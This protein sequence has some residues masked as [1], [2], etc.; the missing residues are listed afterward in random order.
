MNPFVVAAVAFACSI[1]GGLIGVW[2]RPR[3]PESHLDED[4]K[5]LVKIGTGLIGTMSALILGLLVASAT[6]AFSAEDDR[7]QQLATDFV[8]L[9]RGLAHYGPEAA[10]ARVKLRVA[11]EAMRGRVWGA[12][13][14]PPPGFDAPEIAKA[15]GSM[16]DAI[17]D[18]TPHSEGQR[19][20]QARSIEIGATLARTRLALAQGADSSIP[21]PFLVVLMSWLVI[22]F[23]G[24][25]L[26][27]R[28]NA[29]VI[30]VI[31]ACALS[32]A[33]ALFLIIDLDQ[34]FDGLIRVSDDPLREALALLGR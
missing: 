30:V 13:G 10:D 34:P 7:V 32:I 20:I 21:M 23:V 8:L 22:L 28:R 31:L 17:R 16:F 9:D 25:G 24:F 12:D 26:L 4:T 19:Q 2:L 3:L 14:S 18:L 1:G 27:A 5:E 29:T 15:G 11:V 33:T 6:S